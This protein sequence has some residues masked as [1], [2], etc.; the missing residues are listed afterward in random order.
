[1][2]IFK[3]LNLCA[4]L[5]V[6]FAVSNACA[7]PVDGGSGG[8]ATE[9]QRRQSFVKAIHATAMSESISA[10]EIEERFGWRVLKVIL[11]SV[12]SSSTYTFFDVLSEVQISPPYLVLLKDGGWL[13]RVTSL[14]KDICL[15]D[16]DVI[17]VFGN[18]FRGSA[19]MAHP[20]FDSTNASDKVKSNL[21]KFLHGPVFT[22]AKE[23]S[24]TIVDFPFGVSEC[25]RQ[26]AIRRQIQHKR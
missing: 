14:P 4:I 24:V 12:H 18:N 17:N 1:M 19:T 5:L 8:D 13:F 6:L 7:Q 9:L 21:A 2:K 23:G 20:P 11:P 16:I 15:S 25:T 22:I 26:F 10:A 3:L